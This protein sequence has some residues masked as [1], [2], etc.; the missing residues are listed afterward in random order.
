MH[1]VV[2]MCFSQNFGPPIRA[3]FGFTQGDRRAGARLPWVSGFRPASDFPKGAWFPR[4]NYRRGGVH[5]WLT[6]RVST[7]VTDFVWPTVCRVDLLV[8]ERREPLWPLALGAAPEFLAF[9]A[10]KF[11]GVRCL[12]GQPTERE[13]GEWIRAS[14]SLSLSLTFPIVLDPKFGR[15]LSCP[16]PLSLVLTLL[17]DWVL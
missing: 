7:C 2:S 16:L 14:P 12:R 11:Q 15:A 5:V 1:F 8:S 13:A 6:A 17:R 4:R 10:Q 3:H 9:V